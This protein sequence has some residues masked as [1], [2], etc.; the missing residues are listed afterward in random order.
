VRSFLVGDQQQFWLNKL[1][2]VAS[3]GESSL[4]DRVALWAPDSKSRHVISFFR[5][6]RNLKETYIR[7]FLLVMSTAKV[8]NSVHSPPSKIQT[9]QRRALAGCGAV[10]CYWKQ[11]ETGETIAGGIELIIV[12]G[13][14]WQIAEPVTLRNFVDTF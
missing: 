8:A 9:K 5:L 7:L 2:T 6:R 13:L 3:L 14:A 11:P 4:V 12:A 1:G 10:L